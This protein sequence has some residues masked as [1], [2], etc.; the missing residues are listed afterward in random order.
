MHD[1]GC[2]MLGDARQ[3]YWSNDNSELIA[4]SGVDALEN[5]ENG[6]DLLEKNK[7]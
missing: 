2:R 6:D 1:A 7:V 5:Q 3:V 4:D